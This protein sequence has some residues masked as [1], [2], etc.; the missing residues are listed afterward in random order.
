MEI[1]FWMA[2]SSSR[3]EIHPLFY[4]MVHNGRLK[5]SGINRTRLINTNLE[6][7]TAHPASNPPT[8]HSGPT[9]KNL[10]IQEVH[11][12]TD[13]DSNM[14]TSTNQNNDCQDPNDQSLNHDTRMLIHR[15]E[16]RRVVAEAKA[17]IPRP[18][19]STGVWNAAA[20]QEASVEALSS[21][22]RRSDHELSDTLNGTSEDAPI[23]DI[24][25]S[26]HTRDPVKPCK[27]NQMEP[28]G[29]LNECCRASVTSQ[30][31]NH[32]KMAAFEVKLV[33]WKSRKAYNHFKQNR[34][35]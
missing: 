32:G 33:K 21:D 30:L 27:D 18:I 25:A 11:S 16:V 4:E 17:L 20:A 12:N 23:R 1:C 34:Y 35:P 5:T 2:V 15:T 10:Q 29:K 13:E 6:I 9:I 14:N 22:G 24:H 26:S 8:N 28:S 3:Y 31:S 19:C 7:D